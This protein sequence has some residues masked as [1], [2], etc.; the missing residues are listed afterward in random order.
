MLSAEDCIARAKALTEEAERAP[1]GAPRELLETLAENWLSV[2][3]LAEW[4]DHHRLS[5]MYRI[6]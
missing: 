6:R 1:E 3:R 2:A 4:Q 5:P